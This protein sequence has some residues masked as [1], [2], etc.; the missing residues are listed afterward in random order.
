MGVRPSQTASDRRWEKLFAM[1]SILE[2][3]AEAGAFTVHASDIKALDEHSEPRLMAKFDHSSNLPRIFSDNGLCI[4]PIARGRYII[5]R[6]HAY[7]KVEYNSAKPILLPCPRNVES[8]DYESI[9]SEQVALNCAYG[10]GMLS[11][12]LGEGDLLPTVSGRM[13]SGRFSYTI[14]AEGSR[15]ID[16]DVD[17]SQVEIDGAYEGPRSLALVEAKNGLPDD[18]LIRQLYYPYRLW[19]GRTSKIVRPVLLL[20]SNQLFRFFEYSFIEPG[21]HNS[22][23]LTRSATYGLDYGAIT[24]ADVLD[25]LERVA[26][27]H[28]PEMPFPQADSFER[29]INLCELLDQRQMSADDITANYA[30][31]RRQTAYYADAGRYLGLISKR[32]MR[33]GLVYEL[34]DEGRAIMRSPHRTR[35]LRLVGSIVSHGVFATAL[36]ILLRSGCSPTK[37]EIVGIMKGGRL[38]RLDRDVTYRRRASTVAGWIRWISEL[39]S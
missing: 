33:S 19:Y 3:V 29:V 9:T 24:R 16:V 4:L 15:E 6:F 37:A 12:F 35:Q 38:H 18:F 7:Q 17:C 36:R 20:Y 39:I 10:T 26:S 13:G 34:T 5:G 14:R 22:L 27:V 2:G 1:H 11:N 30:F 25:L 23:Q 32:R 28:E 8:I 31:D 21:N